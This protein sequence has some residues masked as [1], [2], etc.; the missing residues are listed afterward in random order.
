[1]GKRALLVY[2]EVHP[3][4]PTLLNPHL[5]AQV[6]R[7]LNGN[8]APFQFIS[9]GRDSEAF[10][11][12]FH[13]PQNESWTGFILHHTTSNLTSQLDESTS[14]FCHDLKCCRSTNGPHSF[15]LISFTQPRRPV[16]EEHRWASAHSDAP[17]IA[18]RYAPRSNRT[19]S[20]PSLA[21]V[22]LSY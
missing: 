3:W 10:A 8:R 2:F 19:T 5:P 13:T 12:A 20:R 16:A 6:K 1:M 22:P 18:R 7:D 17:T 14:H 15:L 11:A 9:L 4:T 21:S